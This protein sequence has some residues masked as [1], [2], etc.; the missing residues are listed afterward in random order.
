MRR[1]VDDGEVKRTGVS[2]GEGRMR[3]RGG[4]KVVD[5]ETRNFVKLDSLIPFA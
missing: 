2:K 3:W 4:E 1:E 5:G